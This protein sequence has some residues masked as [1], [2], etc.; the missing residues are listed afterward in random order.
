MNDA[1]IQKAAPRWPWIVII[2]WLA[3][4]VASFALAQ[5]QGPQQA[6][7]I[8]FVPVAVGRATLD[9]TPI[10]SGFDHVTAITH[11]GDERLFVAEQAG[12]IKVVHPDGRSEAFLDISERVFLGAGEYGLYDL[13]FHPDYT[14][15]GQPGFGTFYV[16]YTRSVV[17]DQQPTVAVVIARFRVTADPDSADPDSEV[18]LLIEEQE[19]EVHKGGA[20]VFD[21]RDNMLYASMG[22][23]LLAFIAQQSNSPK[24]KIIRLEVDRVP[25]NPTGDV[26]ALVN[27][28]IV[29][30]GLRNPW[31]MDLDPETN[32][33]YIG[34]VG[35][36]RWEEI[37]LLS[38]DATIENYGWPCLEGPYANP[39]LVD[40]P[41]CQVTFTPPIYQYTHDDSTGNCAVIA[42][43]VFRPA[44]NPGDGRFIFGD[45]CTREI[46]ALANVNGT[47]EASILGRHTGPMFTTIGEGADGTL[48][49]GSFANSAPVYRMDIP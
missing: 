35:T 41:R 28:T 33:L 26:T 38:L 5:A 25:A 34:D 29:A 30:Y 18:L 8:S 17:F 9:I 42:G 24:G 43:H 21:P 19:S 15:A 2:A 36:A 44:Y 27:M 14:A 32:S 16:S 49:L 22:E 11:A 31:R 1:T 13:A 47:W 7:G 40:D 39:D 3:V 45:L 10:G 46:F 4:M 20:L 23:D 48:Y 37:N 12:V 6:A